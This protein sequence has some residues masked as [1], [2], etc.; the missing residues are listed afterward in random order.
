MQSFPTKVHVAPRPK[1]C[2]LSSVKLLTL[3]CFLVSRSVTFRKLSKQSH[4]VRKEKAQDLL[5]SFSPSTRQFYLENTLLRLHRLLICADFEDCFW[6]KRLLF[7]G[8][9]WLLSLRSLYEF[10]EAF[11]QS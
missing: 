2:S 9:R 4:E 11:E 3:T 5:L 1:V 10:S 7:V 6:G 8:V